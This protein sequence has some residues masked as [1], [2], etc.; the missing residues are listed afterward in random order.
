MSKLGS[1]LIQSLKEAVA[2]AKGD[3]TGTEH[4]PGKSRNADCNDAKSGAE[5]TSI[6]L[7]RLIKREKGPS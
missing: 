5:R 3:G 2:H 4:S 6:V 1:D 7:P